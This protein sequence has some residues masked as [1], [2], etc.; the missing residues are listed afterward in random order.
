MARLGGGQNPRC[1]GEVENDIIG[2]FLVIV[3]L[4]EDQA[5]DK[6][7]APQMTLNAARARRNL[8]SR[9]ARPSFMFA[10]APTCLS[11]KYHPRMKISTKRNLKQV[12]DRHE[13]GDRKRF[14]P[15]LRVDTHFGQQALAA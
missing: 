12:R 4:Q 6:M 2:D 14:G 11:V 3:G 7:N 10:L 15:A 9:A 5:V 8:F 1:D 13:L